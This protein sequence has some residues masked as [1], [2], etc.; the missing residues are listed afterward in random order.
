MIVGRSE[1]LAVIDRL[2]DEAREGRS[3]AS[4]SAVSPESA[5]RRFKTRPPSA[6]AALP[7]S[8]RAESSWK[9]SFLTPDCWSCYD[10]SSPSRSATRTAGRRLAWRARPWAYGWK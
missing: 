7:C 8:G 6:P 1:E 2:L 9:P 5:R 4:F 3:G 10:R